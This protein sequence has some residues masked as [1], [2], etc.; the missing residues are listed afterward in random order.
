MANVDQFESIFRA[1]VKE[2]LEYRQIPIASI[3]IITDLSADEAKVFQKRVQS[4]LSVLGSSED[5]S[6]FLV[7]GDEFQTTEELLQLTAAYTLDLICS[8]RNLHSR[9]WRF[10]H[11]LGEH[12]DV[13]IQ[14]T[15]TPVLILPHPQAGYMAEHAMQD[16][17]EV[18]VVS[19]LVAINHDLIN[20]AVRLTQSTG[21]LFLSHVENQ[22]IFNRYM[23]AIG[24]IDVI[25]TELARTRL[26]EQLLKEPEDYFLSCTEI[27]KEHGITLDIRSMVR[28]GHG[29][30]EYHRQIEARKLDLLVMH[31]KDERQQAM[32]SIAYPLAVELRQIPLL[33]I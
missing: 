31:A 25:D 16:L 27:L 26:A 32:N 4:F 19:D 18:M 24:K 23:D 1:S 20:Y 13:L 7:T 22:Y 12:L 21:T 30:Q 17:K 28:F 10:P 11:S 3:L 14:K 15:T 33:M 9:A 5:L 6:F 8:Y 2:R 29:L